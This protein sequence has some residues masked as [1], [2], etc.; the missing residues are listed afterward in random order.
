LIT[1]GFAICAFAALFVFAQTQIAV[2]TSDTPF[3]L[4]GANVSPGQ[5]VPF[6]PVLPGDVVR[7]GSG[8]VTLAF[9]DGS[10]IVLASGASGRVSLTGQTPTFQLQAGTAHYALKSQPS[11]KLLEGPK[12]VTP[13]SLEGDLS[14]SS[15]KLTEGWWTT[16]RTTAAVIGAGALGGVAVAVGKGKPAS[17]ACENAKGKGKAFD[18]CP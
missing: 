3:Q 5:G 14:L 18:L 10:V 7:A 12:S 6:W 9:P 17:P 8:I 4:R 11:V 13:K 16:S 1:S 15:T 2:V